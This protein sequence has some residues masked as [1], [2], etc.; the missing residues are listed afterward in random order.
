MEIWAYTVTLSDS[1]LSR[2]LSLHFVRATGLILSDDQTDPSKQHDCHNVAWLYSTAIRTMHPRVSD[3]EPSP[4]EWM[5]LVNHLALRNINYAP[6]RTERHSFLQINIRTR[7]YAYFFFVLHV[8][9]ISLARPRTDV[10]SFE[11]TDELK[12]QTKLDSFQFLLTTV[13]TVSIQKLSNLAFSWILSLVSSLS[14]N[15]LIFFGCNIFT[16]VWNSFTCRVYILIKI[17][18]WTLSDIE[19]PCSQL[20][21]SSSGCGKA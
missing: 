6:R 3:G 8:L 5:A 13:L 14:L 17:L 15:L 16:H 9:L 7:A 1:S 19:P 18:F 4:D 12:C 20:F 2:N 21:Y 10:S 11:T